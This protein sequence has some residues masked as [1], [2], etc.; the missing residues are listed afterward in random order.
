MCEAAFF[1]RLQDF[2]Y[3]PIGTG[4]DSGD[5]TSILS[6]DILRRLVDS[7]P[8]RLPRKKPATVQK[9]FP[10]WRVK[11]DLAYEENSRG[12]GEVIE[13]LAARPILDLRVI[14]QIGMHL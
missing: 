4:M 1:M 8:Q 12:R 5:T 10:K 14:C 7:D 3:H 9:G 11:P 6:D 13:G 2:P